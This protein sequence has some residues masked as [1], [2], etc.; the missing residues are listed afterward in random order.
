M[1]QLINVPI[2]D[3]NLHCHS[4]ALLFE[5]IDIGNLLPTFSPICRHHPYI[6]CTSFCIRLHTI[7]DS[8]RIIVLDSGV[9]SEFGTPS[10]LLGNEGG[11]F[12]SLWD[13]H[14]KS[15]EGDEIEFYDILM[16]YLMSCYVILCHVILCC[17]I[18]INECEFVSS[19]ILFF[20]P[21]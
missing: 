6:F 14:Q 8:D 9:M 4:T 15:H 17:V 11:S 3:I 5:I 19:H 12:Q 18:Q 10:D 2:K 20:V 1:Q 16:C 7:I 13:R 21:C